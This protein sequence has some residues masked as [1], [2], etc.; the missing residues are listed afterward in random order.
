MPRVS[1][2]G[3]L[4]VYTHTYICIHIH[5]YIHAYPHACAFLR[6]LNPEYLTITHILGHAVP[7]IHV[8]P[9]ILPS[10]LL[11]THT[12]THTHARTICTYV[13]TYMHEYVHMYRAYTSYI[14]THTV[15]TC[16][17]THK[18]IYTHKLT[19][20]PADSVQFPHHG[21]SRGHAVCRGINKQ[22]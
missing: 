13:D 17:H 14:Y 6:T 19:H 12:Y 21:S 10:R 11:T 4:C 5:T 8:C 18:C 16:M 20:S 7:E 15:H 22:M 1:Q 3:L 2:V 9:F